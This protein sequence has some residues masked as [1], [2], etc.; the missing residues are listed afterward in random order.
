[1]THQH[2]HAEA[3]KTALAEERARRIRAARAFA[4]LDQAA[5][6]QA[7]GVSVVT[8]KRMERGARDTSLDDLYLL[9]DLCN[10]PRE[11]MDVG[12]STSGSGKSGTMTEELHEMRAAIIDAVDARMAALT[13]AL[14]TRDEALAVS[15]QALERL[16]ERAGG[17]S[18]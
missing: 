17:E 14:L 1:M 10:V 11:F 13:E 8:I 7:L 5:F 9:A 18:A 2:N 15:R 6:A 12:F 3:E 4:G 16:R